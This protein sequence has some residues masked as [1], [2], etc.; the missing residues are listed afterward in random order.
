MAVIYSRLMKAD[1]L[2]SNSAIFPILVRAA[3]AYIGVPYGPPVLVYCATRPAI[4]DALVLTEEQALDEVL[5]EFGRDPGTA[6]A[7][8]DL[9]LAAVTEYKT[10]ESE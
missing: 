9:I 6:Q 7:M 4:L 1:Y 2:V 5:R 10:K 3:C 8:D